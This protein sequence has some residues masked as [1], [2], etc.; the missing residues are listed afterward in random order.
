MELGLACPGSHATG[1]VTSLGTDTSDRPLGDPADFGKVVAF[2]CSEPAG[3]VSGVALGVDGA[4]V[5]GLL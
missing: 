1:R 4:S 5:S 2:L 3:F